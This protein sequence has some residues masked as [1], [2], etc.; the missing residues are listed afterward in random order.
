MS[1]RWTFGFF[2]ILL[3]WIF[4]ML[5][6]TIEQAE[7]IIDNCRGKRI[8]V[9]GDVMLD[10]FFWGAVNRIS[11]EAPVPVVDL[12][13]ETVH[14]GGASNVANNLKSL[15]VA[16]LLCGVVGDDNSGKMFLEIAEQS[17][18]DITGVYIH[19][20][21]PTTVKTRIIASNQ[22]VVRVDRE[23]REP[24][25]ED[26]KDFIYQSLAASDKLDAIIF[27][28]YNKGTLPKD[29]IHKII[30]LAKR[31]QIP[32]FVDPKAEN[33]FEYRGVTVFKP[34]RKEAQQSLGVKFRNFDHIVE[35]GRLLLQRLMASGVLLTLGADGMILF[36]QN[37]EVS[38]V[39]TRARKVADV[40][41]AGDTT[42]AT[43]SATYVA[44]A[45]FKEAATIANF[46]AGVVCEEPG[47]VAIN[48]ESLLESIR[49]NHRS[50]RKL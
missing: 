44:G 47:I 24:I 12:E 18:I 22:H 38:H 3:F 5:D 46:A 8:A 33:F 15:G 6:I 28:D 36:E 2:V 40:S 17:G 13:S 27:E 37:G 7:A 29:L 30:E 35:S 23:V 16:P 21:R 39:P 45:T 25:S 20:D 26:A 10:R 34:N 42:I 50:S 14:L 48:I 31:K 1:T 19:P 9:V 4:A 41:G 11:P 32:T 49:K 43:F